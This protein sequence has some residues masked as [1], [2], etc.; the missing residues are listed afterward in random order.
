MRILQ[1]SLGLG[2]SSGG[3][4][5]SITGLTKALSYVD[6]CE[7]CYFVH[8]PSG[9][10]RFDLGRAR[11][12]V[13]HWNDIGNDRSG[14]FERVLDETNPDIVHFHGLWHLTLHNDQ[15]QCRARG[16]PY[17]IAPRGSLDAWSLRQKKLK[18][19]L[20]LWLFQ[21]RDLKLSA[22][23]HVTADMEARHC[24]KA[25]Y[26]GRFI[27]SPNGV[28]LPDKLPPRNF[29]L[30]Y[31]RRMLFLSRMHPKKGLIEL[32]EAWSKASS[33]SNI[34]SDKW[35]CEL[36]YTLNGEEEIQYEREVKRRVEALRLSDR[37]VF[38]G[39][40]DDVRK[41]EAYARSDCFVLPTH[42]ENFGI[43]IAEAL[44][45]GLPVITT[46]NAPWQGI[47][48]NKCGWWIDLTQEQ[49]CNALLEASNLT[50][51]ERFDMG[52]RGKEFV[53]KNFSWPSIANGMVQEYC[54]VI[55]GE[56]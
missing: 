2:D 1:V 8:N 40:L 32:V 7:V 20:A 26:R 12:C 53:L 15:R 13:G 54:R 48:S 46:K 21:M 38:T 11:V 42:T 17:I 5:R 19:K 43:V 44:Y 33:N 16:I 28:N 24:V 4:V 18:K 14:D 37:F 3:P 47:D 35:Q 56:G 34:F 10:E 45:A 29:D 36:V 41:W 27:I 52:K 31:G 25:G 23:L 22:A 6:G 51:D 55:G 9:I 50:D 30:G 39:A 49:L